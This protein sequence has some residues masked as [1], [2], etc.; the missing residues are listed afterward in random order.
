[1]QPIVHDDD[2]PIHQCRCGARQ[3]GL[4]PRDDVVGPCVSKPKDH[5]AHVGSG[6]QREELAEVQVEREENPPFDS[7][8]GEDIWIGQALQVLLPEMYGVVPGRTQP[9]NHPKAHP[10]VGQESQR[11]SCAGCTSSVVSHAAY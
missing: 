1:M 5:D 2:R 7:R 3:N 8:L 6:A 10:H 11:D 4:E 9:F